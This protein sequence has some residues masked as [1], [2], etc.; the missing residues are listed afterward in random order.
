[1]ISSNCLIDSNSYMI[2]YLNTRAQYNSKHNLFLNLPEYHYYSV[3]RYLEIMR[4]I[5]FSKH[6]PHDHYSHSSKDLQG[7]FTLRASNYC[8]NYYQHSIQV[9]HHCTSNY[10]YFINSYHCVVINHIPIRISNTTNHLNYHCQCLSV[11]PMRT[12]LIFSNKT[13]HSSLNNSLSM[14]SALSTY[15]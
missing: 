4:R 13:S 2:N 11:K 7:P 12:L 5:Y 9:K 14:E 8:C 1:M 3:N 15:Y 10:H 6:Y